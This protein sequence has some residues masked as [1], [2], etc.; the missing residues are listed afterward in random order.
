M[1]DIK[2]VNV[3]LSFPDLFVAKEFKIGD[4]KPRFNA[5]FLVEPGSENDK[6][7]QAAIK[8]EAEATYGAKAAAMLASMK[9]QSNKFCYLDGNLKEYEGYAGMRY[10]ACHSKTR[11][12][13]IDRDR[14][15]LSQ[16]D[17]RPYA[18]CY[19]NA[20]V[21][22]YAQKGENAGIRAAFSGVQFSKDGDAFSAGGPA[23][24]DEFD[25]LDTPVGGEDDGG[26]V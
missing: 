18:G 9:G 20:K 6:A 26:L 3:R 2:L 16:E 17:A 8:A 1:A 5:T 7:I 22:I 25:A 13:V 19:V 21:S 24:V 11:P 10:L 4:G 14:T 23:S 15:I 12:L